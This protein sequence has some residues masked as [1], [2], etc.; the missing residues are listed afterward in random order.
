[1]LESLVEG[2][3]DPQVLA[4]LARGRM[5]SKVPELEEGLVGRLG[6]HHALVVRTILARIDFMPRG[7]QGAV[8]RDRQGDH[9]F[10]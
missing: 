10:R 5:R 4:Q 1:M 3:R 2:E 9:P 6:P 7:D 8:G